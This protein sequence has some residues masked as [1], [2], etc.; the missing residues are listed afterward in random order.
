MAKNKMTVSEAFE[1]GKK[2]TRDKMQKVV[3]AGREAVQSFPAQCGTA[4]A[5]GAGMG[6]VDRTGLGLALGERTVPASLIAGTIGAMT[7]MRKSP[8]GRAVILSALAVGSARFADAEAAR[9]G[10]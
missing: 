2:E 4:V 8:Q 10:W 9:M 1:A 3:A 5:V 6:L 7:P